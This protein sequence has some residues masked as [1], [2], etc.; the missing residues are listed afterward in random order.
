MEWEKIV[1]N[2]AAGKGLTSKLYKNT[3]TTR[4]PKNQQP[5]WK[6]GKRTRNRHLPKEDIQMANR[7]M[8]KCSTSLIIRERQIKGTMK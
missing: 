3:W 2:D 6:M 1:L 5:I 8:E 7:H 4:Q